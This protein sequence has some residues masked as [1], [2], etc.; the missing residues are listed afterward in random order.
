MTKILF[1]KKPCLWMSLLAGVLLA[2]PAS[3]APLGTL[4]VDGC[5]GEG[6]TVYAALIDFGPTSCVQAGAGSN[7]TSAYGT[8]TPGVT[9]T[10]VD[11]AGA[12]PQTLM[13]FD[14]PGGTAG[15]LVFILTLAGPG[16]GNLDCSA[17]PCSVFAGSPIILNGALS[18][19]AIL[20]VS[21]TVDDGTGAVA[22][23]GQFSSNFPGMSPSQVKA[24]FVAAG[25]LTSTYSGSI[26]IQAVPEPRT[27]ATFGVGLLMLGLAGAL[28]RRTKA[29]I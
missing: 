7:L 16:S 3:A 5:A 6:V 15:I 9:G 8:I 4:N 27:L 25:S 20:P 19:T 26:V 12:L 13:F 14:P 24:A 29:V 11:L 18:T 23:I 10:I 22:F 1:T 21:G 28:R 2:I 17:P